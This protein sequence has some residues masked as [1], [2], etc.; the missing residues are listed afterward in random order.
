MEMETLFSEQK[1][2]I[3]KCLSEGGHSPLQLA[4]KLNTTIA[5]ISQQLRLLEAANLLKTEKIQSR[6]KGKPRKMF[7]L[8]HDYAYMIPAMEGFAEKKLM[9]LNDHHKA[10][11]KIWFLKNPAMQQQTEKF[12]WAIDPYLSQIKAVA[13][14]QKEENE[15]IVVS[16]K[17]KDIEKKLITISRE[18]KIGKLKSVSQQDV[19]RMAAQRKS[20]FSNDDNLLMIY[21]PAKIMLKLKKQSGGG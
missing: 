9:E 20:P 16:D 13:I 6:D 18:L 15:V 4:A 8:N 11:I 21:D 17:P 12:Y 14:N 3:L 10:I 7:Y 19:E 1:W 5:N 2:N